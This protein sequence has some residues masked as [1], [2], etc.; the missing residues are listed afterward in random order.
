MAGINRQA[1]SADS[2]PARGEKEHDAVGMGVTIL[3]RMDRWKVAN[4]ITMQRC[5]LQVSHR[6]V[7]AD[8]DIDHSRRLPRVEM[9]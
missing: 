1:S 2:D 9:V 3:G 5:L 4:A 7:K 8:D 6:G